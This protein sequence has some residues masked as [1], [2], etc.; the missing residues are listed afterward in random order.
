M[1]L[2]PGKYILVPDTL[3]G[4]APQSSLEF[5]VSAKHLTQVE[6]FYDMVPVIG[7]TIAP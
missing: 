2:P 4:L 6:V 7:T 1:S 5:T 3:F